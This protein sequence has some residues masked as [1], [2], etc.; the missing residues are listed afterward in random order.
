[1]PTILHVPHPTLFNEE[2]LSCVNSLELMLQNE[3]KLLFLFR[4]I[5]QLFCEY[6]KKN[7]ADVGDESLTTSV[8]N[9]LSLG[10]I[11]IRPGADANTYIQ[12]SSPQSRLIRINPAYTHLLCENMED[13]EKHRMKFFIVGKLMHVLGHLLTNV[14]YENAGFQIMFTILRLKLERK[15]LGEKR[16]V[17][18]VMGSR[19]ACLVEDY[20]V[21]TQI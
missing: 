1:M 4:P 12:A 3:Q 17:I 18:V 16:K 9:Y 6:E 21:V 13:T 20:F 19:K 15:Q 14:F 7:Y 2:F 11:S 5:Q 10:P 8:R